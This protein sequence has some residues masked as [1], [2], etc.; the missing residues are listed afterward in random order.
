MSLSVKQL[1][2][3]Q[4]AYSELR[5]ECGGSFMGC[6]VIFATHRETGVF[7]MVAFWTESEVVKMPAGYSDVHEAL[8]AGVEIEWGEDIDREAFRV[9]NHSSE[10][11]TRALEQA[12]VALSA[13][14]DTLFITR[15]DFGGR[16]TV[17]VAELLDLA[18]RRKPA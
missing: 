11:D 17:S 16:E 14:G 4:Q 10:D 18:K 7:A 9:L 6:Q 12:F 1:E 3:L 8:K 5:E 15:D 13:G 2:E